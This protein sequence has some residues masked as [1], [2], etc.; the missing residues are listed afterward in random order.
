MGFKMFDLPTACSQDHEEGE[1]EGEGQSLRGSQAGHV[2]L[3]LECMKWEG[4]Q[5]ISR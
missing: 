4:A 3:I 2:I 5:A 1:V